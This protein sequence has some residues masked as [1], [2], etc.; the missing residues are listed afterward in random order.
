[1]ND[2]LKEMKNNRKAEKYSFS[3]KK[4]CFKLVQPLSSSSIDL[5]MEKTPEKA[6]AVYGV[7]A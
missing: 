5:A 1:M 6:R 7:S 3:K 4:N 2:I